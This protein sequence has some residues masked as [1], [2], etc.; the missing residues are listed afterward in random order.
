[1]SEQAILAIA[2]IVSLMILVGITGIYFARKERRES[3]E[4]HTNTKRN[5]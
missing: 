1:M 4:T 5:R 3:Q 2:P